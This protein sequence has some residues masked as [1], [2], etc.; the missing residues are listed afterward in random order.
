MDHTVEALVDGANELLSAVLD[1][2][3]DCIKVL[4]LAGIIQYVNAQGALALE[5][6]SPTELIGQDWV[7]R[8]PEA[9]QETVRSALGTAR[10]G[11]VARFTAFRPGPDG[12]PCWQAVTI[13]PVRTDHRAITNFL[14][15]ARDITAEMVERD[16]VAAISAEM[17]HR[18]KNAMTIASA[19]VSLSAGSQPA[20]RD[21]AAEIVARLDQ[22]A[23]VQ[24]LVLTH[25]AETPLAT[26]VPM[27]AAAYG[28]PTLLEIAPLP[29]VQL[30][31]SAMQALALAFGELAS[32]SLKYGALRQ[33]RPIQVTGI[34]TDSDLDLTWHEQ[35]E[36]GPPRPG[37]QG[38]GLIERIVRGA[39]GSLARQTDA[40]R[41][42]ARIRLPLARARP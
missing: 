16:R 21:F 41:H 1:Q 29:E 39:G 17:R 20:R 35:T 2:T 33:E 38:L 26:L 32:N 15:I 5:L 12:S 19:I 25:G 23:A 8:W 18:L 6:Q 24:E 27:L 10:A 36:F 40:G 42:V 11:S 31:E 13:T 37:S 4:D 7:S 34:A 9:M 28:G 3:Q 22:L 14:T 30:D